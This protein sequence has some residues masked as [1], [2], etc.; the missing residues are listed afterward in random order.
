[1]PNYLTQLQNDLDRLKT[2]IEHI[3]GTTD[4]AG[5]VAATGDGIVQSA[6]MLVTSSQQLKDAAEGLVVA[7]DK[8]FPEH[9]EK[10]NSRIETVNNSVATVTGAV[11]NLSA[12]CGRLRDRTDIL[13]EIS[14]KGQALHRISLCLL[15]GIFVEASLLIGL[16]LHFRK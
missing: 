16:F 8:K 6:G 7:V 3:N 14:K 10:I 5:K 2:A 15:I 4:A 9:F 11:Q 1:M 12:D 13:I